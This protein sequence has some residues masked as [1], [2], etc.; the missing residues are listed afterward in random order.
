MTPSGRAFLLVIIIFRFAHHCTTGEEFDWHVLYSQAE[1]TLC[2][3]MVER[4]RGEGECN[5]PVDIPGSGVG[6]E[7]SESKRLSSRAL[8][9]M[10]SFHQALEKLR[11]R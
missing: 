3:R 7:T 11:I 5:C 4:D 9:Q 1:G 6:A 10:T 8:V 2:A